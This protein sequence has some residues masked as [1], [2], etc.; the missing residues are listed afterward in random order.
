METVAI[1]I[2]NAN[3]VLFVLCTNFFGKFTMKILQTQVCFD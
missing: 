1:I 2:V 3:V